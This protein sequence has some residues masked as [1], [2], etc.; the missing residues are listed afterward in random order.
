M[1]T[2]SQKF[3]KYHTRKWMDVFLYHRN[4]HCS[5]FLSDTLPLKQNTLFWILLYTFPE[6]QRLLALSHHPHLNYSLSLVPDPSARA[7]WSISLRNS[8]VIS[9]LTLSLLPPAATHHRVCFRPGNYP[10]QS[11]NV[12]RWFVWR[13][14][15]KYDSAHCWKRLMLKNVGGVV[16]KQLFHL[17]FTFYIIFFYFTDKYF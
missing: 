7:F 17:A 12:C 15:C 2:G 3:C 9:L 1:L 10:S 11:G 13:I 4:W 5:P 16:L 14:V 8:V 6:G